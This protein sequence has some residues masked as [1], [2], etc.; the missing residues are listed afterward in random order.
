MF[1]EQKN[2]SRNR[3]PKETN[4]INSTLKNCNEILIGAQVSVNFTTQQ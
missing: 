1:R 4:K 2:V 3:I